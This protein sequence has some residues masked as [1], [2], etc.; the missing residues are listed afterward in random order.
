[1]FS[2]R[3]TAEITV[4]DPRKGTTKGQNCTRLDLPWEHSVSRSAGACDSDRSLNL[5]VAISFSLNCV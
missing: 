3:L 2:G 4:I 5:A 1:M